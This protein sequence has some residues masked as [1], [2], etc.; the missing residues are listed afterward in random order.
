MKVG[1][2]KNS[3]KKLKEVTKMSPH[4]Q[5]KTENEKLFLEETNRKE[6][7]KAKGKLTN[8]VKSPTKGGMPE[9]AKCKSS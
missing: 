3:L 4:C 1:T 6:D 5:R 8:V 2:E 7:M 9:K